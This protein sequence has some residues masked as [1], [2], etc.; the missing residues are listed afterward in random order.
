GAVA[1]ALDDLEISAPARAL[2][3]EIHG[4]EGSRDSIVVSTGFLMNPGMSIKSKGCVALHIFKSPTPVKENQR[5][6]WVTQA[7]TVEDQ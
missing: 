3:A 6:M 7:P 1:M 5:L 4:G 2:L